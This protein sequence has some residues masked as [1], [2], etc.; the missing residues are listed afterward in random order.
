M[1]S[2][3]R[4]RTSLQEYN[5]N[6]QAFQRGEA[7][8]WHLLVPPAAR[9]VLS[10]DEVKRQSSIFEIIQAERDYVNDLETLRD[11]FVE[12]LRTASPPIV[13]SEQTSTFIRE[14]F[15][16]FQQ[17]LALHKRLVASLFERQRDQHPLILSVAD[18]FLRTALDSEFVSAYQR[19]LSS[20]PIAELH[21]RSQMDKNAQYRHFV[22][23]FNENPRTAKRNL[24]IY[25]NRPITRLP[26]LTLVL[27]TVLK[28]TPEGHEDLETIPTVISIL[29]DCVR[30]SQPGISS[31]EDKANCWSISQSLIFRRG[32]L[33]DM[34]TSDPTRTLVRSGQVA[35]KV[36]PS[37]ST[38]NDYLAVLFDNYFVLTN[39]DNKGVAITRYV[40]SRP[41]PL[42][43]LR[44]ASFDGPSEVRKRSTDR[45][46]GENITVYPFTIYH[47]VE[48][49][50][51]RYTLYVESESIR[52]KWQTAFMDALAVY[53][54]RQE[55]NMW[56]EPRVI[57]D[58]P[59]QYRDSRYGT[60]SGSVTGKIAA[61]VPFCKSGRDFILTATSSGVYASLRDEPSAS[62]VL[63]VSSV[64]SMAA[65]T[66]VGAKIFNY[67]VL[68][69]NYDLYAYSLDAVAN[70][71]LDGTKS[72]VDSSKE[73]LSVD[74]TNNT[75]MFF[76]LAVFGDSSP[77]YFATKKLLQTASTLHA[78]KALEANKP[79][80]GKK[81]PHFE[82]FG[83]PAYVPKSA[84]D[85]AFLS[86][87]LGICTSDGIVIADPKNLSTAR[88]T[89][90]AFDPRPSPAMSLLKDNVEDALPLGFAR[91]DLEKRELLVVYDTIGVYITKHG[92]PARNC[93]FLR[94]ETKIKSFAEVGP[95]ILLFS[96]EFIEV[97]E[98]VTGRLVQ[99]VEVQDARLLFAPRA[100]SPADKVLIAVQGKR[101]DRGVFDDQIMELLPTKEIVRS[102]VTQSAALWHEWDMS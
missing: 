73:L 91:S 64:K 95:H 5:A 62:E 19:Y 18:I 75:V 31:S 25:L 96:T 40:V 80:N 29:S 4:I 56:Y 30:R 76:R 3:S 55:G 36:E 79:G 101:S 17:I 90:P 33:I 15:R 53:D 85:I 68:L 94:W 14:V 70:T 38:W 22:D 27:E 44:L 7:Q 54:A 43:F 34:N 35:R 102:P 99:V 21:H 78:L 83:E 51:R 59:F 52:R 86:S 100:G 9:E 57:V 23:V 45:F 49:V 65:V 97:R 42:G 81:H 88:D 2:D 26:R 6:L 11:L 10:S 12:P 20:H 16:N 39:E 58:G 77:V 89:V 72:G 46:H 41:I 74:S 98:T 63:K 69:S 32:E 37:W 47:A 66:R 84:H 60:I 87:V 61:A 82:T 93:M 1:R 13:P 8:E 28:C 92:V 48:K 71:V 67:L 24:T 50:D